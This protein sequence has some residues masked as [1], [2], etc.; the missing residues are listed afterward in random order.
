M[1]DEDQDGAAVMGRTLQ[2]LRIK[3]TFLNKSFQQ[4]IMSTDERGKKSFNFSNL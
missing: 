3:G 1:G 4:G 2:E